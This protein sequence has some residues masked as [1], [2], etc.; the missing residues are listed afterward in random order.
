MS[1]I[2][3]PKKSQSEPL[4]STSVFGAS[5]FGAVKNLAK[6]P[7]SPSLHLFP[8][9][10][11]KP[12]GQSLHP[13]MGQLHCGDEDLPGFQETWHPKTVTGGHRRSHRSVWHKFSKDHLVL[14]CP[15]T[16]YQ[17]AGQ[18]RINHWILGRNYNQ[19]PRTNWANSSQQWVEA[20]SP[21][22][23]LLQASARRNRFRGW[24]ERLNVTMWS[25]ISQV[26]VCFPRKCFKLTSASTASL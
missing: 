8:W 17:N 5:P 16:T 15:F 9:H 14:K 22:G 18:F 12:Q 21:E 11:V 4:A 7:R 24:R 23:F 26:D 20:H 6:S 25:S 2:I 10:V 1:W 3:Y 19:Q 13:A